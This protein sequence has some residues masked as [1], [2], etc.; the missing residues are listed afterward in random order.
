M[1]GELN[2]LTYLLRAGACAT[3][4]QLTHFLMVG[5]HLACLLCILYHSVKI[6]YRQLTL[7]K[8]PM[9]SQHD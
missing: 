6:Y 7:T 5:M 2:L 8:K 9:C 3:G 1:K 4:S